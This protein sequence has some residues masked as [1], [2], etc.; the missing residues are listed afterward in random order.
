MKGNHNNRHKQYETD[1]KTD[2]VQKAFFKSVLH[3]TRKLFK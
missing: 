3:T 2:A 1:R